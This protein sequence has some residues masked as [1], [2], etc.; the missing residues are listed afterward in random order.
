[1]LTVDRPDGV[2]DV[3]CGQLAS[4]RD[5]SLS[6]RQSLRKT[7]P[8]N[9]AAFFQDLGSAR[10]MNCS[11]DPA[12]TKQRRICRV[13]NRIDFLLR[14]I[15]DYDAYAPIEKVLVRSISFHQSNL[16]MTRLFQC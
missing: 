14:N 1:M 12:A 9:L 16:I 6:C 4:S 13:Y 10:A 15:A 3:K 11:I 8:T 5:D 2:D 7:R